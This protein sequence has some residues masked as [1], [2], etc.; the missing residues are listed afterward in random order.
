Q[1]QGIWITLGIISM[2]FFSFFDYKKL[3]YIAFPF[4]MGSIILL[5]L[6]LIPHIGHSAG[7]ARRWIDLGFFSLQPTEFAKVATIIYLASWFIQKEK[8]R[9][10]SFFILLS[11]LMLLIFMQPDME[12]AIIIFSLSIIIYFVAG[13]ELR[14]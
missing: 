4:M 10:F 2:T 7:G 9:F 8:H 11:I 6:V 12:T 13:N 5:L 1:L 14:Y 3:Y